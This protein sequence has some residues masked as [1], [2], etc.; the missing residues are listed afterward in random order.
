MAEACDRAE[1]DSG[2]RGRRFKSC[3]PDSE[4]RESTRETVDSRPSSFTVRDAAAVVL[5]RR[6]DAEASRGVASNRRRPANTVFAGAVLEGNVTAR[7]SPSWRRDQALRS[8]GAITARL[9]PPQ[10]TRKQPGGEN[11]DATARDARGTQEQAPR[12]LTSV[13]KWRLS[14]TEQNRYE[15]HDRHREKGGESHCPPNR[16]ACHDEPLLPVTARHFTPSRSVGDGLGWCNAQGRPS[17]SSANAD[18]LAANR[19]PRLAFS[20]RRGEVL[21]PRSGRS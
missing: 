17:G 5:Q 18:R 16:P 3:L 1:P 6:R 21:Q 12:H 11:A 4:G 20:A 2:P 7:E 10:A 19:S 14:K 9:R 8:W 13:V 15:C